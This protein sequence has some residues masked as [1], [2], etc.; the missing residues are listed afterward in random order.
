MSACVCLFL[1]VSQM[2][3]AVGARGMCVHV[4]VYV[5]DCVCGVRGKDTKQ[6]C[7]CV[8]MCVYACVCLSVCVCAC[9]CETGRR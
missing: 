1:C 8:N 9:S 5:Y 3:K 7:V 6:Q 2:G 4:L